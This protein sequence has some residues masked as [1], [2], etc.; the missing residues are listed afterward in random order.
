MKK[1]NIQVFNF[2]DQE[3][4]VLINNE[5]QEPWFVAK[6]VCDL[7]EIRNSRDAIKRLNSSECDAVG[8]TDTIGRTQRKTIIKESGLY[9]LIMRS[10]KKEAEQFQNW[11]TG[12]VIP[13]IRKTGKYGVQE[14]SLE[15]RAL[16]LI[17]ELHERVEEQ[18]KQIAELK[19][20]AE[21]TD[22]VY[23]AETAHS[24]SQVAKM[25][26]LKGGRNTL[27]KRLRE[28]KILNQNNEPYQKY[29]KYFRLIMKE[30]TNTSKEICT[31]T[32]LRALPAGVDYIR[33]RLDND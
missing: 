12:D 30:Y 24:I 23:T 3:L 13:T 33:K 22:R 20:K 21:F 29:M 18:K 16:I 15:Q 6:Q 11:I 4:T 28:L 32:A 17:S 25:L 31:T 10:R 2:R 7:L 19:P 5:T 9:K 1:D 26:Q 27:F 14:L 8:L